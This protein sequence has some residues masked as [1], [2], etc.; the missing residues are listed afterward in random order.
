MNPNIKFLSLLVLVVVALGLGWYFVSN[1]VP[2]PIDD[3]GGEVVKDENT[4]EI[5]GVLVTEA[6]LADTGSK[7]PA[8]FPRDIPVEQINVTESYRAVYEER[9]A[10]QY[11]VSYT[12]N[13]SRDA[14]WDTYNSYLKSAGYSIDTT[15]TSKSQGQIMGSRENDTLFII[16]SARSGLTLVQIN[17]L[18][19][20][21]AN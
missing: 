11:T 7:L 14:L 1:R 19:R 15:S 20:E 18:D 17:L 2:A 5:N 3:V 21:N 8:G 10:T 13:K 9:G 6:S 16:I 4:K 12:S